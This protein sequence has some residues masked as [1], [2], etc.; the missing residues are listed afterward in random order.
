MIQN[1]IRIRRGVSRAYID[2]FLDTTKEDNI[3]AIREFLKNVERDTRIFMTTKNVP[4][5]FPVVSI[6][7]GKRK[8]TTS[9]E[10]RVTQKPSKW[11][12]VSDALKA[13]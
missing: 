12:F 10:D 6:K 11:K 5:R 13:L 2:N 7:K 1:P 4:D 8:L 9:E 3:V